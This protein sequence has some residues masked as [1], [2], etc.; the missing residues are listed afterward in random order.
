MQSLHNWCALLDILG[1]VVL[2]PLEV[3]V[4]HLSHLV[5]V[6]L[7]FLLVGPGV[8]GVQDLGFNIVKSLGIAK[9]EDWKGVELGV[10]KRAVVDGVDDV[11]G[12][13]DADALNNERVTFPMP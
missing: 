9:V 7:V 12:S 4:E 6:H 8:L 5:Q 10:G 11:P 13:L 3:G 2:E 1:G